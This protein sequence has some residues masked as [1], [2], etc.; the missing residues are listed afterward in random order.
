M[1]VFAIVAWRSSARDFG[2]KREDG[3]LPEQNAGAGL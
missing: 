1:F 3:A 2:F